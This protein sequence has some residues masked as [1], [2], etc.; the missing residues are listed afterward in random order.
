MDPQIHLFADDGNLDLT[1]LLASNDDGGP[2]LNSLINA[3]LPAG[4]YVL[5]VSDWSFSSAE[6]VS[7]DN[8]DS[9]P[10]SGVYQVIIP[11]SQTRPYLILRMV[12]VIYMNSKPANCKESVIIFA[13]QMLKMALHLASL[14]QL[15][16][17]TQ[18]VIK[19]AY[20]L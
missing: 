20:Y 8:S 5:A 17:Q 18:K 16:L 4:D 10:S 6:A 15:C 1:D 11:L 7:G 12:Q 14:L 2:G 3:Y 9:M 19:L 13:V